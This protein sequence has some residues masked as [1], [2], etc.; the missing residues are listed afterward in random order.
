MK[1]WLQNLNLIR[2]KVPM[3]RLISVQMLCNLNF[4]MANF[5]L[6]MELNVNLTKGSL[7]RVLIE[8]CYAWLDLNILSLSLS[9]SLSL[10]GANCE[11]PMEVLVTGLTHRIDPFYLI[12]FSVSEWEREKEKGYYEDRKGWSKWSNLSP[13]GHNM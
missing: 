12:L 6:D 7:I 5:A 2:E 10:L 11:C 13:Y 1:W 8:L 3:E 4:K 9:L